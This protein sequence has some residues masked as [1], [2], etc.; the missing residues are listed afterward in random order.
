MPK[1]VP[2]LRI[3][4][5]ILFAIAACF[6]LFSGNSSATKHL[7]IALLED[8][9][10][11]QDLTSV[12]ADFSVMNELGVHA[13][14]GSFGWDDYEPDRGKFDFKW[15]HQFA[16]LAAANGITLRPYIGYTPPWA[17]KGGTDKDAWNDP[18]KRLYDWQDFVGHL[19]Q[20]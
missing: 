17:A 16:D 11:G 4:V 2:R 13:W 18:P 3:P 10:K 19:V 15:L 1:I 7:T 8:Y 14:R 9:D 20:P 6:S 5:A 12:S